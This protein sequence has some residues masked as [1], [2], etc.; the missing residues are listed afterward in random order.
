MGILQYDKKIL[1][2]QKYEIILHIFWF[3]LSVLVVF[4]SYKLGLG[5]F[6]NPRQGF[7]P[8]W[9]GLFLTILLLISILRGLIIIYKKS[10]SYEVIKEEQN[11][12]NFW[13]IFI[14]LVSLFAYALFLK[15]LGFAITT[16]LFLFILFWK[17]GSKMIFALVI[18]FLTVL[19]TYFV[20]TYLGVRFPGGILGWIL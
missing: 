8:F 20:F 4:L 15:I 9:E 14:T 13:N 19:I 3:A 17:M 11:Q 18:S 2:K 5:E 16:F 10:S 6:R 12:I 1:H 7:V